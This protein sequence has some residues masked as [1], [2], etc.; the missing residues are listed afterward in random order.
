MKKIAFIGLGIMGKPMA[1]NLLKAG[2]QLSVYARRAETLADFVSPAVT[3]CDNPA[4][5][6]TATDLCITMLSD[7]PDVEEVTLGNHGIIHG[8]TADSVIIDMSTINPSASKKIAQQLSV[9]KVH[10]LDA[11]VSGGEQGAINGTLSIMVGGDK[12]SFD[13]ALPVLK[14]MGSNIVRVGEHGAGQVAKACNQLLVAQTVAATAEV[15]ILAQA[16]GVDARL[17]QKALLGGFAGSKVLE[18]HGERI[19]N[20][21]FAPGFKARLHL[22]DLRIVNSLAREMRLNLPG[23]K[24]AL[25]NMRQ[26]VKEGNGEFDS[27]AIAT[28]IRKKSGCISRSEQKRS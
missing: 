2:Y 1:A 10:T 6:V 20:H 18:V 5:A 23:I 27:S 26:L 3:V 13:R 11:P 22:K 7:T 8:A 4:A 28:V 16:A 24:H 19:L 25:E 9:K 17:V 12:A 14:C 15:L 21:D